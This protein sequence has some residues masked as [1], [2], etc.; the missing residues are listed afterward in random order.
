M[1]RRDFFATAAATAVAAVFPVPEAPKL[2]TVRRYCYATDTWTKVRM[3]EL[4]N[5]DVFEIV[6]FGIFRACTEPEKLPTGRWHIMSDAEIDP[7]TNQW[8]SYHV[9]RSAPCPPPTLPLALA[10]EHEPR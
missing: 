4:R 8:T 7:A 3:Y 9:D 10:P 6:D 2:R 1:D 5:G